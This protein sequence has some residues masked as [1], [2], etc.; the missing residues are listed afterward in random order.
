MTTTIG[1]AAAP[2]L[3]EPTLHLNIETVWVLQR[4]LADQVRDRWDDH[5]GLLALPD[6]PADLTD[7]A[8]VQ[9]FYRQDLGGDLPRKG[10][11][12][13]VGYDI[14]EHRVHG[15]PGRT[16]DDASVHGGWPADDPAPQMLPGHRSGEQLPS[17]PL[18]AHDST[19]IDRASLSLRPT[20][21]RG[22]LPGAVRV[23]AHWSHSGVLELRHGRRI[24]RRHHAHLARPWFPPT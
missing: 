16:T 8:A 7:S 21:G 3:P 20:G 1:P 18:E 2:E 24:H 10:Q 15:A 14:A 9:A 13:D 4:A 23:P 22:D 19:D 17:E 11:L 5:R 6:S 12:F